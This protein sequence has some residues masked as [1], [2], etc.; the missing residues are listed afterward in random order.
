MARIIP[1]IVLALP[2]T[3]HAQQARLPT[4]RLVAAPRLPLPGL[5]DSNTPMVR[6]LVDGEPRLFAMVSW[7]GT[8]S[9]SMGRTL[10]D[11]PPASPVEFKPEAIAG[12]WMESLIVAEDG[13]WYGYYHQERPAEVCG[14]EERY[15]PRLGAARSHDHGKTWESLGVILEMPDDTNAC[16]SL[17]RYVLGGA[18]D[19]SVM[20]DKD[21]KDLYFFF[22]QYVS[23]RSS[24]GVAVG[25]MAWADRDAPVGRMAI[26]Q[27]GLWI[28][29]RERSDS[30][31]QEVAWEYP[32]GTPLVPPA[33]PW[34]DGD[35]AADVYWGSTVHWNTHL[36]Q[37]VMLINRA[38]D[39][40]FVMDGIYV[41]FSATLEDPRAWSAPRKV[42][43]GGGWYAQIVGLESDGTDKVA[44]QRARLFYDGR[45]EYFIDFMR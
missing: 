33:R 9:L 39:E 30:A 2:L 13:T 6:D 28:P 27:H 23:D 44:G 34:H 10:D 11:L 21:A 4:V 41:A 3:L 8:P 36:Q 45:S 29:G 17:N 19:V 42:L 37:Y 20:L 1:A 18:G 43:N 14:R 15:I 40:S 22:S 16:D 38:K 7:G 12:V 24:Q 35:P 32:V 26:W 31:S 5:V 25:R